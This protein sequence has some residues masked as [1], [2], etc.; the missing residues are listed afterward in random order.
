MQGKKILIAVTGSIA[1]YK[2][3]ELCRMFI[4][5]GAEVQVMMTPSAKDFVSDLALAT[6]T[7]K[8]VLINLFDEDTW[9]NHVMLGRW[10]DCIL[11]APASCNTI[12]KLTHG[13]CDN[14]L[15]ATCLSAT[16]PILIAPAMDEDMWHHSSTK[17]NLATLQQDG[18]HILPSQYGE[19]A[20][21]LTGMG[22]MMELA[23]IVQYVSDFVQPKQALKN[24]KVIITAGPTFENI[25]PVRFIGNYSSGKMGIAIAEQMAANGAQVYLV[26]GPS[27]EKV[28][29]KNITT[30]KVRS[31]QEMFT[32]ATTLFKKSDIAIM[33]AAVADFTPKKVANQKIKKGTED[34]VTIELVKTK[35]ILAQLGQ[36][37]TAKQCVVGFA[38]ES[39]NEEAYAQKKLKTKKADIIVLNSL[40][41]EGAG[42]GV[43][44]NKVTIY[45]KKGTKTE[46]TLKPKTEVAKDI[47]NYIIK[48]C[49]LDK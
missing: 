13:I 1:A 24:K 11:M 5:Q 21:G 31:A 44:T 28:V 30:Y 48:Y 6:L 17:R 37:K 42:F 36:S 16:C 49:K 7:R 26:L 3:P 27:K 12:A 39:N 2:I 46:G 41:D 38:L 10:A 35:D 47:V 43:D 25:D 33:S 32:K 19:L 40:N 45:D 20:S 15:L 23:D 22:R 8:K 14:F 29:H 18:C 9:S 4:K 34:T